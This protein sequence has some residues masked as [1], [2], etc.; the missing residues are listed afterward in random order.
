MLH[1]R[2]GTTGKYEV[3]MCEFEL[4]DAANGYGDG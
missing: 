3:K 2:N 4:S 1:N